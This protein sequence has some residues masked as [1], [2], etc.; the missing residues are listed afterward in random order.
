MPRFAG[1]ATAW[2]EAAKGLGGRPTQNPNTATIACWSKEQ[3]PPWGHVAWVTKVSLAL[4]GV[5]RLGSDVSV[6]TVDEWNFQREAHGVRNVKIG[7]S[8]TKGLQGFIL[9]PGVTSGA[10]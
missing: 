8:D 10:S 2:C 1:N 5:H 3:F 4:P 9:V 7:T 6:F